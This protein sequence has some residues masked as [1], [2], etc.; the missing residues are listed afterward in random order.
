MTRQELYGLLVCF[1]LAPRVFAFGTEHSALETQITISDNK[2]EA[3]F[4]VTANPGLELTFDA[5]WT[6]EVSN[7]KNLDVID[8][9]DLIVKEFDRSISG[10]RFKA[11][12]SQKAESISFDYKVKA[13]VCTEDKTRCYPQTHKGSIVHPLKAS[14]PDPSNP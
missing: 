3:I 10:M 5:P 2:I 9:K 7:T 6:L 1:L 4:V 11:N 13:F 14:K 8:K 12:A